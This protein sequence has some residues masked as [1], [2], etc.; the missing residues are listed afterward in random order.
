MDSTRLSGKVIR[1]I[2]NKTML[3]HCI[4][5]AK[6]IGPEVI[7]ATGAYSF[8]LP[9]ALEARACGVK[10]YA[11]EYWK[12]GVNMIPEDDVLLRFIFVGL[13]GKADYI[14]RICADQPFFSVE[15]VKELMECLDHKPDY[16]AHYET[17]NKF[18]CY[19]T[20][21]YLPWGYFNEIVSLEALMKSYGRASDKEKM[22]V[23]EYI[24]KHPESFVIEGVYLK[25]LPE[26]R[27]SIN[28]KEDL[29]KVE[30][31]FKKGILK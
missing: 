15:A 9:I 4:D 7:V 23:T 10:C 25:E 29:Y 27:V 5:R 14:I 18:P 19:P 20:I 17:E 12:D 26:N 1:K 11:V 6:Q 13:I 2:G 8:N 22:N 30:E 28:T 24:Y 31:L 16:M 21:A 3:H